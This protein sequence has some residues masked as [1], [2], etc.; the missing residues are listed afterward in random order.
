MFSTE[1]SR[2]QTGGNKKEDALI[3]V[4][5]EKNVKKC[6]KI[7]IPTKDYPKVCLEVTHTKYK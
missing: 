1:I 4:L 3:D 2:I 5:K 7:L 6:E